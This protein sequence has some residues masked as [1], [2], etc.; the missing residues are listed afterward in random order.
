MVANMYK[1]LS[2][3]MI[4]FTK[5]HI[6]AS[7]TVVVCYVIHLKFHYHHGYALNSLLKSTINVNNFIPLIMFSAE[8]KVGLKALLVLRWSRIRDIQNVIIP[9]FY[10]HFT[11]QCLGVMERKCFQEWILCM[12]GWWLET[13][14]YS[15]Q[16]VIWTQM[17]GWMTGDLWQLAV[18][19]VLISWRE[20][21]CFAISE[22]K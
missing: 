12:M 5:C 21:I 7:K 2:S 22:E 3:S 15:G 13:L 11:N 14:L 16:E 4:G 9:L 10:H 17:G 1:C 6:F 19:T 18:V 8:E 20:A